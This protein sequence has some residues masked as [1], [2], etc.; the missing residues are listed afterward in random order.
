[1]RLSGLFCDC[2]IFCYITFLGLGKFDKYIK[3]LYV[4]ES[5]STILLLLPLE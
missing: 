1:M 3:K 2:F 5:D 4:Y